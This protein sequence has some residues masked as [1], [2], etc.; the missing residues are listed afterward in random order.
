MNYTSSTRLHVFSSTV[1]IGENKFVH[2]VKNPV[3]VSV[4]ERGLE[5]P[6]EA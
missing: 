3:V 1:E 2:M 6:G 5:L 4:L